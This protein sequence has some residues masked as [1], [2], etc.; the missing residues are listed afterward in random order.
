MRP[1]RSQ[2]AWLVAS[3]VVLMAW[4]LTSGDARGALTDVSASPVRFSSPADALVPDTRSADFH[5]RGPRFAAARKPKSSRAEAQN[6]PEVDS[7][8]IFGFTSGTDLGE[9][10]EKQVEIELGGAFG[11]SAGSYTALMKEVAFKYMV[12]PDTRLA[13]AAAT[14]YHNISGVPGLDDRHQLAF[15]GLSFELKHRFLDR[16]KAPFGLAVS[17]APSW[18]PTDETSG[19]RVREYGAE[20]IVAIDKELVSN[21][22]FGAFNLIYELS[23]SRTLMIPEWERESTL[24]L[25][26]AASVQVHPGIFLGLEARYFRSYE[27]LA[28]QSLQ[29]EALFLGPTFYAKLAKCCFIGGAW[30]VQVWGREVGNGGSLDLVNFERHQATLKVGIEF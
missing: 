23:T 6:E 4:A 26:T 18:S 14:V 19:E 7:E 12:L 29:G 17:V 1:Q 27:G 21:R 28:L 24:G 5:V 10:G 3:A 11:K 22:I 2:S 15:Q 13:F 8:D 20:V 9:V 25:A 16:T 30:N